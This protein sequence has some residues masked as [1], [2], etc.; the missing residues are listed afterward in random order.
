MKASHVFCSLISIALGIGLMGAYQMH[1]EIDKL[2]QG[3]AS[4]S[5][6]FAN[7]VTAINQ[8][9]SPVSSPPTQNIVTPKT[10]D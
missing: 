9:L 3:Q 1:C 6:Q 7:L 4:Q 5:Q 8:R 10:E 2:K